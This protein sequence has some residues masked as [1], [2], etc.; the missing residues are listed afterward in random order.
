[1]GWLFRCC[2]YRLRTCR[3]GEVQAFVPSCG[4][5]KVGGAFSMRVYTIIAFP[6]FLKICS[7][8]GGSHLCLYVVWCYKV[9]L[10]EVR[11]AFYLNTGNFCSNI[12]RNAFFVSASK[13][14]CPHFLSQETILALLTQSSDLDDLAESEEENSS[15]I[16]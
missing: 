7:V 1:M 10:S 4:A 8:W 15:A 9:G 12:R 16:L 3:A 11:V 2:L 5:G 6:W 14:A 13:Q